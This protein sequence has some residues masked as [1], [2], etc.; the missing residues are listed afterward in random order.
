MKSNIN[1]WMPMMIATLLLLCFGTIA[2]SNKQNSGTT[3]A[4]ASTTIPAQT[5]TQPDFEQ[6]RQNAEQQVR[7]EVGAYVKALSASGRHSTNRRC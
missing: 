6:Q 7:P 5:P 3:S 1:I 4:A 2:C